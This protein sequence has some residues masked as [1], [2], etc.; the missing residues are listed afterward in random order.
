MQDLVDMGY[1]YDET[2]S[3]IDNSEAVRPF[4][5]FNTLQCVSGN[6]QNSDMHICQISRTTLF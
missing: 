1:G 3:F 4:Y 2:D 5:V 6:I